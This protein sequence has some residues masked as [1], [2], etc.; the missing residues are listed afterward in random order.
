M[1]RNIILCIGSVKSKQY[2]EARLALLRKGVKA[3][4]CHVKASLN[5]DPFRVAED[6]EELLL[7]QRSNLP[8]G[9]DVDEDTLEKF[10]L[11]YFRNLG[12]QQF[13]KAFQWGGWIEW[14][15][16]IRPD[17]VRAIVIGDEGNFTAVDE[18]LLASIAMCIEGTWPIR[19][20]RPPIYDVDSYTG[21]RTKA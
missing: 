17:E 15:V 8:Y 9:G 1:S 20:S 5:L 3:S 6:C 19:G 12:A 21:E 11:S 13:I 7:T 2:Q 18:E 16:G 10:F 14:F 4:I